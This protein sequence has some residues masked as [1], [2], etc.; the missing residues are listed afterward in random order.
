MIMKSQFTTIKNQEKKSLV[1]PLPSKWV[2]SYL[3]LTMLF[4]Y[5][6]DNNPKSGSIK[7][8]QD[9]DRVFYK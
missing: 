9:N 7:N 6:P 5:P 8:T 3:N 4:L 2:H 1:F